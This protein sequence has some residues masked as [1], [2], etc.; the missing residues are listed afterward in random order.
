[1]VKALDRKLF[2]DLARLRGQLLAI[3]VVVAVGVATVVITHGSYRSLLLARDAYFTSYRFADIFAHLVRAPEAIGARIAA[4]PGVATVETRVVVDVLLDVPDLPE[5]ATGRL[6]SIPARGRPALNDIYLRS[7]RFPDRNSGR[8][9]L[10]SEAFAEANHLAPG[11]RLAALINGRRQ[12]LEIVG[13]ALSPEFVYEIQGGGT[14]LPD[15]RRFGILWMRRN[16]LAATFD[17]QGAFNDVS[18]TLAPGSDTAD[19]ITRVDRLLA[20]YGGLGAYGHDEQ[21]SARFLRDELAQNRVSGTIVPAIFLGVAAFLL[22]VVLARLVATERTQIG[23]LKAF[24]YSDLAIGLHYLGLALVA[25]AVGA[26]LGIAL[27]IWLGHVVNAAYAEYYRFPSFPYRFDVTAVLLGIGISAAAAVVG[28]IGAVRRAA[29]L[30]PAEAMRPEPPPRYRPGPI[31]RLGLHRLLSPPG[32]IVLR[33]LERRP[34]KASLSALGVAFS[35]AILVVGYFSF[36]SLEAL[37]DLQFRQVQRD[38]LTMAFT[39]P[40]PAGVVHDL[41]HLPGVM[42]V[43]AFRMVPARVRIGH[44]SRRVAISGLLPD[45]RL[46]RLIDARRHEVRLPPGGALLTTKLAEVLGARAGDTLTIEVLEG[47][48]AVRRVAVAGVVDEPIG[49]SVYMDR[50]ALAQLLH[51]GLTVSGAYLA[52]DA[53]REEAL[54]T[55]LKELPTVAGSARRQAA[56]RS[57]DETIGHSIGVVTTILVLSASAIAV[58]VIYN[59]ARI[60]LS[61][62]AR[63]LASLRVLGFTRDETT[64]ML[65]GEQL[66]LAAIGTPIGLVLGYG[67]SWA[68]AMNYQWEMFRLPL[69]VS[70]RTYA[71][72]VIVVALAVLATAA[73][74]RR[75]V[76]RLDLVSA[77]KTGE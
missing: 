18:L 20:P 65:L 41:A 42:R 59:S 54:F 46:H 40:R 2:R 60:A 58:A 33:N 39:Q 62:R 24:G 35:A 63:E 17:M 28:A 29:S 57:F 56:L 51:E 55:R 22:N 47:T 43:E 61:E 37:I 69:V 26:V 19:V 1:M 68:M 36:D 25:L 27:G 32:R 75:R 52:V 45:G 9:V 3:A 13:V 34:L 5:P 73:V 53:S 4:V 14:W 12:M 70:S 11:S 15:N 64:R 66:V 31:E 7:G 48:R 38:D 10:A 71:F 16:V 6:V 44:R 72:A 49:L 8:E 74:V 76:H 30:P 21:I 50:A 67:L 23:V 77:L